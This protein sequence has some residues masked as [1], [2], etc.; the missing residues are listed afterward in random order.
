[1]VFKSHPDLRSVI[2]RQLVESKPTRPLRTTVQ[3][4]GL[5]SGEIR[6]RASSGERLFIFQWRLT[7]LLGTNDN[8]IIKSSQIKFLLIS[9]IIISTM[10]TEYS[11]WRNETAVRLDAKLQQVH[12][13]SIKEQRNV[14]T[15]MCTSRWKYLLIWSL[16]FEFGFHRDTDTVAVMTT[17]GDWRATL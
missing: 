16:G 1:M 17:Q 7:M 9:F 14:H 4:K 13:Y 6:L 12:A 11:M 10:Y 2:R 15:C 5:S 8:R 3:S